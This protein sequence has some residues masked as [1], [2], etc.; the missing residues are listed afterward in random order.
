M[1][2]RTLKN[3]DY[4]GYYLKFKKTL[5]F[6]HFLQILCKFSHGCLHFFTLSKFTPKYGLY[7]CNILFIVFDIL[8][9]KISD[10]DSDQ[11]RNV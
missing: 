8:E 6:G 3:V 11:S 9:I 4:F 1:S 10:V 2:P 5:K 7:M